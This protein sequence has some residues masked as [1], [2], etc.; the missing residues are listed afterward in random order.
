[1]AKIGSAVTRRLIERLSGP[2]GASEVLGELVGGGQNA[3]AVRVQNASAELADRAGGLQY[4]VVNVYCEKI[5]NDLREKFRAFSGRVAMAIEV[6][7]SQDRLDGMQDALE[8]CTDAL[9]E[10]LT[11][12]RGDWGGGMFYDGAYEVSFSAVK[13]G[14]K[15]FIQVAKVTFEIGVSRN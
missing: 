12:S 1:M 7:H 8:V 11:T 13:S 6:R 3:G 14:G 9:T 15:N 5:V 4:P 2:G 10:Y